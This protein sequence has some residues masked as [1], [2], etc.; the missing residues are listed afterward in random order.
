MK[1]NVT[2]VGHIGRDLHLY[3]EDIEVINERLKDYIYGGLLFS[4][5]TN[6]LQIQSLKD[7][8]SLLRNE[9]RNKQEYGYGGR[10]GHISYQLGLLGYKPKI[11]CEV[12]SDY[13]RKYPGF[14]DGGY[15]EH[16]AKAGVDTKVLELRIV[17]DN[18]KNQRNFDD[19]IMRNYRER[20]NEYGILLVNNKELP[21]IICVYDKMKRSI[22][23]Y[24]DTKSPTQIQRFRPAPIELLKKTDFIFITSAEDT[25]CSKVSREGQLLD[26]KVVM[27]VG[28]QNWRP[29]ILK[30]TLFNINV[31]I[32]NPNEIKGIFS[33]FNLKGN[34]FYELF[35]IL[36]KN[37]EVIIVHDKQKLTT[38]FYDR[39]MFSKESN[40]PRNIGP[41]KTKIRVNNIGCS[42]GFASGFLGFYCKGLEIID[43]VRAGMIISASVWEGVDV[44]K[45]L[46]TKE[47]FFKR[48]KESWGRYYSS[49]KIEILEK[50]FK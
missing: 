24:D 17:P 36:R 28:S 22:F 49:K 13:N 26:K 37:I 6:I 43:C 21:L 31:L 10:A 27:D 16:L 4:E 9:S 15:L 23:F 8:I 20:I 42:D 29:E 3:V 5:I 44:H 30:N 33:L 11:V 1:E 7:F 40:L 19:F 32:A 50:L 12:G 39:D 14:Y 25:F 18:L 34:D 47:S 2:I 46:L 41:I 38:A 45:Q 48:F 35:R